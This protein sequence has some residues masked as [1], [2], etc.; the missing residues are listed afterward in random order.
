MKSRATLLV[1]S[2]AAALA[3][4]SCRSPF[5]SEYENRI[6][7]VDSVAVPETVVVRRGFP[8]KIWTEGPNLCWKK[9]VDSVL[10]TNTTVDITPYDRAYVGSGSC[11]QAPTSF[12]H[13]V[14]LAFG[15]R[16]TG[17]INIRH[18]LRNVSGGDSLATLTRT[19]VVQ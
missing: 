1:V 7:V 16:G 3:L 8:V 10:G 17:T 14:S 13:V 19:V 4:G 18:R 11:A 9:G 5:E 2:V 6:S 12:T 15:A